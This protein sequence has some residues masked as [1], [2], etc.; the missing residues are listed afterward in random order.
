MTGPFI[1]GLT[2]SSSFFSKLP[3]S[4]HDPL[5]LYQTPESRESQ[6]QI[7]QSNPKSHLQVSGISLLVTAKRSDDFLHALTII[8]LLHA[9]FIHAYSYFPINNGRSYS[10]QVKR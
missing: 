9:Y 4:I 1:V 2:V 10:I 7:F 6:G 3:S 5:L 8:S